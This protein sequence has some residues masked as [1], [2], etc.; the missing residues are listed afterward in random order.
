M[1]WGSRCPAPLSAGHWEYR[2]R[3]RWLAADTCSSLPLCWTWHP[4]PSSLRWFCDHAHHTDREG[5]SPDDC[6]RV[7]LLPPGAG[8]K[9][10]VWLQDHTSPQQCWPWEAPLCE[11]I[12]SLVAFVICLM[13]NSKFGVWYLKLMGLM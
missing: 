8:G 7:W 1:H 2:A 11:F 6:M 4:C 10:R 13:I 5:E 3:E 12:V 9:P